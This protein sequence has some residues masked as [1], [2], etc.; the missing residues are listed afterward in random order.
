MLLL[1]PFLKNLSKGKTKKPVA[2]RLRSEIFIKLS[3]K[4]KEGS[5]KFGFEVVAL[6]EKIWQ[7]ASMKGTNSKNR[8]LLYHIAGLLGYGK[9]KEEDASDDEDN[10]K[11]GEDE[12]HDEDDGN[13]NKDEDDGEDAGE[14]EESEEE[15][16]APPKKV[17]PL[18]TKATP[19]ATKA[20]T[21]EGQSSRGS[22]QPAKLTKPAPQK[23]PTPEPQTPPTQRVLKPVLKSPDQKKEKKGSV[24][25]SPEVIAASAKK[26]AAPGGFSLRLLPPRR[27]K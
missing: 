11:D 25:F 8:G 18:P 4:M 24:H 1:R 6:G 22:A 26:P 23:E 10:D 19:K 12:K 9:G 14:D 5:T 3:N 7:L 17:A 15:V 16:K 13:E 20:V 27:K 21:P 2:R